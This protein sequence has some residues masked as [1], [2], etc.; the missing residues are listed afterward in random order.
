MVEV[1]SEITWLGTWIKAQAQL[2]ARDYANA[3]QTYKIMD[4]HGLLKD[5]TSLLV[6]MAYCYHYMC[7]DNK[8]IS[9]LQKVFFVYY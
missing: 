1:S 4:T 7:E 3:I 2:H 8:A 6:N 9:I 5:N